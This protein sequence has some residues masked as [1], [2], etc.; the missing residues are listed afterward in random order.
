MASATDRLILPIN[1]IFHHRCEG[2]LFIAL[3]SA[4]RAAFWLVVHAPQM[5]TIGVIIQS[6]RLG[7]KTHLAQ[8]IFCQNVGLY[9][10][11]SAQ[12]TN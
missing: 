12:P 10:E 3:A 8:Q 7:K 1:D 2:F 9:E 5:F 11:R 6:R 4:S